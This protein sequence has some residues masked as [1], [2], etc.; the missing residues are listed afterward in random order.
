MFYD[1]DHAPATPVG[2]LMQEASARTGFSVAEIE[3]LVDSELETEHLLQYI[4]AVMHN[5]M[6]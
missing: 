3:N 4:S 5:R 6:N 1:R 2:Q